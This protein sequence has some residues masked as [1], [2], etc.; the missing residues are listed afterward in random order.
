VPPAKRSRPRR[1]LGV[2]LAFAAGTVLGISLVYLG[3]FRR[4]IRRDGSADYR[5]FQA[6]LDEV[7][8]K[9]ARVRS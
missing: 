3:V 4:R 9:S 6:A 1:A 7:R 2:A 8:G 5:E